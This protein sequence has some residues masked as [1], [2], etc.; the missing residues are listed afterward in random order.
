[1]DFRKLLITAAAVGA[2]FCLERPAAANQTL[3]YEDFQSDALGTY[4]GAIGFDLVNWDVQN[5]RPVAIITDPTADPGRD[6][7]LDFTTGAVNSGR[8]TSNMGFDLFAGREYI[9]EFDVY[10]EA[11]GGS[12]VLT[13]QAG[14]YTTSFNN[15]TFPTPGVWE[16]RTITFTVTTDFSGEPILFTHSGGASLTNGFLL[17]NVTVSATPEPSTLLLAGLGAPLAAWLK[18]RKKAKDATASEEVAA[19]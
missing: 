1:M 13:F 18:R 3:I 19:A 11:A 15:T 16:H 12:P 17:D 9:V 5:G 7:V 10:R 4:S 14:D 8:I 6:R 2:L